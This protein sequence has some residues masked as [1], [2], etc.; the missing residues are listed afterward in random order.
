MT[1][2]RDAAHP[3]GDRESAAGPPP[4]GCAPAV[5]PMRG[6][7]GPGLRLYTQSLQL[8]FDSRL[9]FFSWP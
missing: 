2:G 3:A 1:R 5:G 8:A 4:P 7:M 9:R 6:S